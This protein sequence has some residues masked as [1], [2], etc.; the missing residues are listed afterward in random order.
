M[1]M[2]GIH[3]EPLSEC[4][5]LLGPVQLTITDLEG[6]KSKIFLK[7]NKVNLIIHKENL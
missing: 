4:Q 3:P 5:F 6:N 2:C 7:E 1:Q